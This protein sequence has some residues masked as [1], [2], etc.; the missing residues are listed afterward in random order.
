MAD[1]A[2]REVPK[3]VGD[4]TPPWLTQVF[5]SQL[6]EGVLVTDVCAEQI[7][8]DTGFASRI[9]RLHLVGSAGVPATVVAKLPAK[10][11]VR[12][13]ISVLGGYERELLF[14]QR[15]AN[16]VPISTPRVYAADIACSSDDFV[17]ILEDLESWESG[18]HLVG[19]TIDRAR[20]CLEELA[21]LHA[22][23][24][25]PANA[26]VPMLFPSI[27]GPVARDLFVPMFASGWQVYRER[28]ETVVSGAV[29]RYAEGFA[30]HAP[31]ALTVM[32]EQPVLLHGDIRADN[33]FFDGAR[34]KVIDLQFMAHGAGAVDVAY[35]ISQSLPTEVRRDAGDE[36]L[37]REY[38]D[39]FRTSGGD[40]YAFD[41]AWRQY[42][43]ATAY[44][45]VI[46]TIL[47]TGWDTM[48]PRSQALCLALVDRAVAAIDDT[49][50]YEVVA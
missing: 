22:W 7:A 34:L 15:F 18:D 48:A 20:L 43:A 8:E 40:D 41:D 13:A 35:L 10:P 27:D 25:Q 50:A 33:M 49:A 24:R 36:A 29:T 30:A 3:T 44:W 45:I 17:L 14:Y 26:G 6:G 39:R 42:R 28:S 21:A 2:L 12:A 9:Y 1:P 5:R 37:V 23:S 32:A 46:P 4:I 11:E 19:L 16:S 31:T 38:L 47:L